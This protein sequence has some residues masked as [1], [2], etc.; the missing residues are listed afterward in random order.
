VK[1]NEGLNVLMM[2][3]VFVI[4]RNFEDFILCCFSLSLILLLQTN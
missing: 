2:M 1:K 3:M 4:V